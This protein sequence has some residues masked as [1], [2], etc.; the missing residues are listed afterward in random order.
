MA[1]EFTVYTWLEKENRIQED[2]FRR[3]SRSLQKKGETFEVI[4]FYHD[5]N[6]P[7][8]RGKYENLRYWRLHKD[9][10]SAQTVLM[11]EALR[12]SRSGILVF[13][14]PGVLARKT[15]LYRLANLVRLDNAMAWLDLR[16]GFLAQKENVFS[17]YAKKIG[18]FFMAGQQELYARLNASFDFLNACFFAINREKINQIFSELP[19]EEKAVLLNSDKP[20]KGY[21]NYYFFHLLNKYHAGICNNQRSGSYDF[22][23]EKKGVFYSYKNTYAL[24]RLMFA[25]DNFY[26]RFS[27]YRFLLPVMHLTQGIFFVLIWFYPWKSIVFVLF[28]LMLASGLMVSLFVKKRQWS[29]FSMFVWF[30]SWL[31]A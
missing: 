28:Y 16:K 14:S 22:T 3:W 30:F 11:N 21:L 19:Q 20:G 1:V 2:N 24:V 15:D 9:M 29:A 5:G 17:H 12:Y 13:V 27:P 4:V 23:M 25:S 8:I 10:L 18:W 26:F 31:M 7:E 6:S